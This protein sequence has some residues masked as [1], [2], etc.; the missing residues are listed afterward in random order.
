MERITMALSVFS[1]TCINTALPCLLD[2]L[3]FLIDIVRQHL[4]ITSVDI[5]IMD[6]TV[7]YRLYST[8]TVFVYLPNKQF[9]TV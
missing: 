7:H 2:F 5:A 9:F 6:Y 4:S 1:D 8:Q 3:K